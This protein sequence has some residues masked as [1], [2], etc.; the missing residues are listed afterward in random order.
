MAFASFSVAISLL[1]NP[2][3]RSTPALGASGGDG[4]AD[5]VR[6]KRGAG[7]GW[8]MPSTVTKV[9]R[10]LLW[11]WFGASSS[12]RTGAKQASLPSRRRHHSSRVFVLNTAASFS[13]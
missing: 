3:S 7:A 4:V 2:H 9:P 10:A 12:E 8:V 5:G 6:L 11:G 13:L 1:L